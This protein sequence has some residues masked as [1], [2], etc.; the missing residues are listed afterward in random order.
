MDICT[1]D[2]GHEVDLWL[3]A[4]LKTLVEIWLGHRTLDAARA[5]D[6]LRLDGAPSELRDFETWFALSHFARSAGPESELVQVQAQN[7]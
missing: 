7:P 5:D 4:T 2:P 3:T 1:Q 6:T